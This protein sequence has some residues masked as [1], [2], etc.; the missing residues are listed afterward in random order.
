MLNLDEIEDESNGIYKG[1]GVDR[2]LL[3]LMECRNKKITGSDQL[4]INSGHSVQ[5]KR[6][7]CRHLKRSLSPIARKLTC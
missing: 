1:Y 5:A 4:F 7:P 3:T 6:P 2:L